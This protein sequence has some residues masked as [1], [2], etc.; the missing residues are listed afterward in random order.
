MNGFAYFDATDGATNHDRELWRSNGK[1]AGT[2]LVHDINPSGESD[3]ENLQPIGH[4]LY[5]AARDEG[6]NDS[7]LWRSNG[8]HAGTKLVKEFFPGSVDGGF[9]GRSPTSEAPSTSAPATTRTAPSRG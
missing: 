9:L 6:G 8:T 7:E 5:F 1:S 3:P 2:K 4:T